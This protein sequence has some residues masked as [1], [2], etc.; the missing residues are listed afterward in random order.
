GRA[1]ELFL[2]ARDRLPAYAAVTA[3]LAS[4]LS[5]SGDRT[6]AIALL[7]PL[8]AASDDPAYA[9]QLSVLLREAGQ[10]AEAEQL[11]RQARARY[12]DLLKRHPEAYGGP[13]VRFFL[14]A[15]GNPAR[16]LTLAQ[17]NLALLPRSAEAHALAIEAAVA[18]G[19]PSRACALVDA[20]LRLPVQSAHVRA[21]AARAL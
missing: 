3:H 4:V 10:V 9:G 14:G 12:E 2:G 11:Q 17:G 5:A 8:L 21:V 7:R 1:R 20:A 13:A 18:A 19:P 16:A 6:Q 15:G